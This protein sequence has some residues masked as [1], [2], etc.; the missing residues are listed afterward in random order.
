MMF[1]TEGA[2]TQNGIDLKSSQFVL[3]TQFLQIKILIFSNFNM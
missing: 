1:F 3:F 2:F